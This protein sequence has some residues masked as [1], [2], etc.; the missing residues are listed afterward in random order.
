MVQAIEKSV[1]ELLADSLVAHDVSHLFGLIGD[2]NL[3]MVDAFIRTG[4][5]KYIACNHEASSVLAA[6]GYAQVSGKTG[7][8][9]ITHGPAL[10]NVMTALVEGVK[11]CIPLVLLCGDTPPNDIEHLQSVDQ[12]E[13]IK[14]TGAGF[15]EMRN[16]DTAMQDLARAFRL[17]AVERKPVVFNMRVDLQWEKAPAVQPPVMSTLSIRAVVP[18][19]D[20]FDEAVGMIA[21]A[22]RPLILA[23]RGAVEPEAKAALLDLAL[24]LEAPVATTLKASGLFHGEPFNLGVFGTLSNPVA[25]ETIVQSDCIIAFGASLSWLTTVSGAY[26]EGKRVVQILGDMQENSRRTEP[27]VALV[28]DPVLTA[29]RIIE[30]LDEAEIPPSQNTDEDLR[31]R[32]EKQAEEFATLPSLP[33]TTSGTVDL[34]ATLRHLEAVIP[35]DRVLVTDLGRFIH[36]TWKVFTVT[37][38]ENFVFTA[39]YASI[40]LGLGETI[41][42]AI[43]GEDR[44]TLLIAGDGGFMMGGLVELSTAIRE[45][46]DLVVIVCNDASYGAEHIQFL[47][48]SMDPTT[49]LLFTPDFA[50]VARAMGAAGVRVS[51]NNDVPAALEAIKNRQGPVL[52]ELLLDPNNIPSN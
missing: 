52:I 12:R 25:A 31:E 47:H 46:L 32:L 27:G 44:T 1:C 6:I 40:G 20:M 36:S 13:F 4:K 45:N 9:T 17:A 22:R 51:D 18:E 21:S 10:T 14:A 15:V 38:P 29:R 42:A 41:G 8:A 7:V 30:M 24:R 43:A 23:G 35:K 50:A 28:G 2:A 39:H 16:P 34:L 48:R 3:F 33:A 26:L 37:R 49:S 5:G 11:G 19:G